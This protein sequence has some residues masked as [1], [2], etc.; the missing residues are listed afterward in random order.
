[1][2]SVYGEIVKYNLFVLYFLVV[3]WSIYGVLVLTCKYGVCVV[4]EYCVFCVNVAWIFCV[5]CINGR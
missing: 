1:M 5:W 2:Y 3:V 4:C